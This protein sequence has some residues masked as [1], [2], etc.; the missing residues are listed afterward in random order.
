MMQRPDWDVF[1]LDL[2]ARMALRSTC[3]RR[4]VGCIL[5]VDRRI[6]AAGYNGA[7]SGD[8]HCTDAGCNMVGGHCITAVHAEI[9]AICDAA[10]RG[11]SVDGATCYCTDAPCIWCAKTV[12]SA[13]IARI[14]YVRGYDDGA[15]MEY[16]AAHGERVQVQQMEVGQ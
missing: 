14:V 16:L 4:A 8:T 2:A 9:N 6:V 15:N 13:G 7:V 1:F 11:V 10:R 5:T 3:P 12:I